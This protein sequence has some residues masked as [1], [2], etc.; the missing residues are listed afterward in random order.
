MPSGQKPKAR[1]CEGIGVT[2]KGL[3]TSLDRD[4]R[5]ELRNP[6]RRPG[7]TLSTGFAMRGSRWPI[8]SSR[9]RH[10]AALWPPACSFR[11]LPCRCQGMPLD[12]VE[13]SDLAAPSMITGRLTLAIVVAGVVLRRAGDRRIRLASYVPRHGRGS[14]CSC[15][16][17]SS[18]GDPRLPPAAHRRDDLDS[19]LDV[20]STHPSSLLAKLL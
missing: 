19:S 1:A 5:I 4:R 6:H 12:W 3:T 15:C 16:S 7:V 10:P 14:R 20:W 8:C 2:P 13:P 9:W 18:P 11:F 17:A